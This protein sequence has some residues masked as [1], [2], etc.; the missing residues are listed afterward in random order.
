MGLSKSQRN[1]RIAPQEQQSQ[2]LQVK[3]SK[4]FVT[5]THSS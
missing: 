5:K 4:E 3:E 1:V 2:R